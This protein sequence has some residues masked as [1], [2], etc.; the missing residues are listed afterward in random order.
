[1]P[2]WPAAP[3]PQYALPDQFQQLPGMPVAEIA[4]DGGPPKTFG[5]G[6]DDGDTFR[7]KIPLTNAQV[8]EFW[9]WYRGDL[10]DGETEFDWVLPVERTPQ[11]FAFLVKPRVRHVDGD[12]YEASMLLETRDSVKRFG[13]RGRSTSQATAQIKL[14]AS[15]SFQGTSG[16]IGDFQLG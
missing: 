6:T 11:R 15:F 9:T 14:G 5:T 10:R 4:M 1:M 16:S 3:F 12:I 13:F 8:D 7:F 2:S